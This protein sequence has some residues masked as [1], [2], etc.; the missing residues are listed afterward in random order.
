LSDT[1]TKRYFG[2]F[3][4]KSDGEVDLGRAR[5]EFTEDNWAEFQRIVGI[6]SELRPFVID[7]LS[8]K[9]EFEALSEVGPS[10]VDS[11]EGTPDMLSYTGVAQT[12]AMALAQ[13][14]FSNFLAATTCLKDRGA[15]RLRERYGK[16]SLELAKF[17]AADH[18]AYDASFAYRIFYNLRN[19][20]QHHDLPISTIPIDAKRNE[21]GQLKA[22]IKL[23]LRPQELL[24]SSRIQKSFREKEL[25]HQTADLDLLPMAKEVFELHGAIVKIVLDLHAD[26]LIEMQEYA[27]VV[28]T[29]A[30]M[31]RGAIPV[32]WEGALQPARHH[33]FSFDE[34]ASLIHLYEEFVA[35]GIALGPK[36]ETSGGLAQRN[37][38][39]HVDAG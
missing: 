15:T 5:Q 22:T 25:V 32:I 28:F 39:I 4:T 3:L 35:A 2:W 24:G 33:H 7:Y 29:K 8:L 20:A 26:R 21:T 30:G 36:M 27:R 16:D 14:V 37:P 13:G 18:D 34:L 12:R 23:V 38:P 17:C 19:F 11:I 10:I 31:P 6:T 9:N 1:A